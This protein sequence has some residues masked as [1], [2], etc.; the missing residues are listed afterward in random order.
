VHAQRGV[1]VIDAEPGPLAVAPDLAGGRAVAA[2]AGAL[3]SMPY[4]TGRQLGGEGA[5]VPPGIQAAVAD[6]PE[7][8][9]GADVVPAWPPP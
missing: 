4:L 1:K 9:D 2:V 7:V 8:V 3:D 6:V 5:A